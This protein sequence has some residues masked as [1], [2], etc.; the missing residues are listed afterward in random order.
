MSPK[1]TSPKLEKTLDENQ[2][3]IM[4]ILHKFYFMMFSHFKTCLRLNY[5]KLLYRCDLRE[6]NYIDTSQ[7]KKKKKKKKTCKTHVMALFIRDATLKM[8]ALY[9][10]STLALLYLP[11]KLWHVMMQMTTIFIVTTKK[12]QI[13]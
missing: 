4:N 5:V 9:S 10:T 1:F 11:T 7:E 13:L 2:V 8:L 3:I 12:L 6:N